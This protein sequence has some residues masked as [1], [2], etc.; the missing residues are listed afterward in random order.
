MK[1]HGPPQAIV[2]DR[3]PPYGA[4]LQALG[5]QHRQETGRSLKD[6]AENSHLPLRRRERAMLRFRRMR[7]L[8]TFAAVHASVSSHFNQDPSLSFRPAFKAGRAA[9]L[10]EWHQLCAA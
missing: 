5:A 6:R 7:S 8:Q 2:T 4:A 1:R 10:D 3:L 9:A